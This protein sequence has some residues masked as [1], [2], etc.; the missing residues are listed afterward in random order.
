MSWG[1]DTISK[2]G[3]TSIDID[4]LM[5]MVD[6]IKHRQDSLNINLKKIDDLLAK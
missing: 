2:Y 3:L 5:Q 4:Y 1:V 6:L